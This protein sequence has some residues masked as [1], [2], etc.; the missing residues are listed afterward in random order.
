VSAD[1]LA[2]AAGAL[3]IAGSTVL[4][5]YSPLAAIVLALGAEEAPREARPA[6][7]R[8]RSVIARR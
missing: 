3:V 7:P 8:E 6:E 5:F 1:G 2:P 4:S